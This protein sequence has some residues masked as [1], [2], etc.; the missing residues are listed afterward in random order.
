[1]LRIAVTGGIAC[2]KSLVGSILASKGIPVCEA[3]DVAHDVMLPGGAVFDDVVARFGEGVVGE[4]GRI[5]RR[6]L[7]RIVF[8]DP[9][10]LKALNV[11]VHPATMA[12]VDQWLAGQSGSVVAA[13]IPLLYEAGLWE[14]WERVI[15]VSAPAERQREW[16][17]DRGWHGDVAEARILAQ[18]QVREKERRAD[19]VVKNVGDR[20]LVECQVRIVLNDILEKQTWAK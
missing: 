19:Y 20:D 14:N 7:G 3:D 15:C 9:A 13:V 10:S 18:L 17:A 5:D 1:M 16:L 8:G 6:E 4:D 11:L 2:G 12:E